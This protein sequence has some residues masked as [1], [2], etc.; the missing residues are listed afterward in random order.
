M[1]AIQMTGP[2][3]TP[4]ASET[5]R[6]VPVEAPDVSVVMAVRNGERFIAD[7]IS[8]VLGQTFRNFE[9]VVIDDGS[10]DQTQEI[11]KQFQDARMRVSAQSPLGLAK[12]LNSGV[13]AARANLI[14]RMDAD[15]VSQP[16]RLERQVTFMRE[17][18]ETGLLGTATNVIDE[19]GVGLRSWAPL[20]E[21]HDI[22]SALIKSN[23][24]AHSSVMLR[25]QVFE[26]V[27]GYADMPFA[28]D[29]DL[30][31]RIAAIS[32]VANL[33]EPLVLRR[34]RCRRAG[35]A[36]DSAQAKWAMKARWNALRRGGYSPL[37]VRHLVKPAMGAIAP[38]PVR[39]L[40]R[41]LAERRAA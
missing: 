32:R 10:S 27:G 3:Y 31:L 1:V 20:T 24:F 2:V 23:Q 37:S 6:T 5:V 22:R 11:L 9:L 39:E 8:S 40:A 38:A 14:A 17:H 30:W 19:N 26:Q 28:Q 18:P 4:P 25:K 13:R 35:A 21:D 36:R 15:D 34:E 12:A 16:A 41:V 29:Y 7:A 33:S